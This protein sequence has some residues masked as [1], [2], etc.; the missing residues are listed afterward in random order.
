MPQMPYFVEKGVLF[1]VVDS[2]FDNRA[3][4]ISFLQHLRTGGNLWDGGAL[5]QSELPA[6]TGVA[7]TA[8][9][10]AHVHDHWVGTSTWAVL[11]PLWDA[12]AAA[13]AGTPQ[14][15]GAA[16]GWWLGWVGDVDAIM[17]QTFV[18]AIEVSL[19]IASGASP[20]NSPRNWPIDFMFVCAAPIFQSF[21]TW[22]EHGPAKK[23]GQVS[24]MVSTP[25][26]ELP[27]PAVHV[28]LYPGALPAADRRTGEYKLN[29][30]TNSADVL[31]PR[32]FWV[33]GHESLVGHAPPSTALNPVGSWAMDPM[34]ISEGPVVTV[35]P[36]ELD[37]G[38]RS[39]GRSY[40]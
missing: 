25:M 23:A 1:S 36:L 9:V 33:I 29:P 27:P 14:P 37:G 2:Y 17:R 18:R 19:G 7:D 4:K 26:F 12:W 3:N 40:P 5:D 16:V 21:L 34:H 6:E 39:I 35:R 13:P 15:V 28:G 11:K 10:R 30:G 24:V 31:V 32:G 20:V 8:A 38:T 22:R